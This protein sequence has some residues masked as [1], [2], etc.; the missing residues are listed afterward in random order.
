MDCDDDVSTITS[1]DCDTSSSFDD[2]DN[3]DP[4]QIFT[5]DIEKLASDTLEFDFYTREGVDAWVTN[6]YV[7]AFPLLAETVFTDTMPSAFIL[8]S[9]IFSLI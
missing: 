9:K 4:Q 1:D 6:N 8:L 5:A 7:D 2:N 3:K